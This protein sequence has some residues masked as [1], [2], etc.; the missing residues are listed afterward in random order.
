MNR[1]F[2]AA[3]LVLLL[4]AC[5]S[6]SVLTQ[7]KGAPALSA[8]VAQF[9]E[10]RYPE[11]TR[12]LNTALELGLASTADLARAHKYLAFI[13][14]VTNRV[15]QCREEFARALEANPSLELEPSEASHP[16]W[17]PVF[18]SARAQLRR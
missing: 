4:S 18:K 14:C 9:E 11:A 15:P 10:G 17:G 2:G 1:T 6:V 12:S 8:G 13:D 5:A 16:I 7:G 3:A